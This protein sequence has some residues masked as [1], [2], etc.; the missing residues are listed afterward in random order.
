[1]V[2]FSTLA[3][4]V[5][6]VGIALLAVKAAQHGPL[7]AEAWTPP[8][9]LPEL[10]PNT[11]LRDYGEKIFNG[12]VLGPESI[13]FDARTKWIYSGVMSGEIIRFKE[14]DAHPESFLWLNASCASLPAAQTKDYFAYDPALEP[15]CGRPLGMRVDQ[16]ANALLVIE[17]YS[18]L[19]SIDL[20]TRD[21]T[22]LSSGSTFANDFDFDGNDIFFTETSTRWGRSRVVLEV[23]AT[24]RKSR[25][26]HLSR[27]TRE[28]TVLKDD[29]P[30]TN[31]VT[32]SHD[33][34]LV[35]FVCGYSICTWDRNA[36]HYKGT[37][38]DNLPC[39]PDNIRRHPSDG[40]TYLLTCGTRRL[41]PFALPDFLAPYPK[42][43]EFMVFLIGYNPHI[44]INVAPRHSMV[45]RVDLA[46]QSIV[47]SAQDPTGS[48]GFS[49]EAERV[50]DCLYIGSWKD[51]FI[52]RVPWAK[53][54][55]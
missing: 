3:A 8:D 43:R 55:F 50:G 36:N 24:R 23:L 29:L 2:L 39:Q 20:D 13:A 15:V 21:V 10:E 28:L 41:S 40:K 1:M 53:T 44:A 32:F 38:I 45:L 16:D 54:G 14:G 47:S 6:A 31:G 37:S 5:L 27:D 12:E 25:F 30:M 22:R 42:V 49:S 4:A 11:I 33:R 19:L 52:L 17:S 51:P 35:H 34:T 48:S 26:L 18:G 9:K 7:D 46:S